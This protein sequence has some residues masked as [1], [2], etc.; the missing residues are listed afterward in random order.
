MIAV[1]RGRGCR[2]TREQTVLLGLVSEELLG[3]QVLR[4][5]ALDALSVEALLTEARSQ[6]VELMAAEAVLRRADAFGLSPEQITALQSFA[7]RHLAH[8]LKIAFSQE[9][10]IR[11]L[12]DH[13]YLILKGMAAAAY[14][15]KPHQRRQG[16]VDFLIDAGELSE[17]SALLEQN[18]YQKWQ[19]E[20]V[21]HVVFKKPGA[22]LEMHF[23]VSGIPRGEAGE[24]IRDALAG[25]VDRRK[26]VSFDDWRFYA[27]DD[28]DQALILLLHMQHHMLAEGLGVRH[29][30]DWAAFTDR[31][32]DAPFWQSLMP[33]LKSVGLL[34]YAQVLT[35]TCALFFGSACPAWAD[36]EEDLCRAV[37]EDVLAGGNFGRKDAV[38]SAGGYLI[39][40]HGKEGTEK[41]MTK[42]AWFTLVHSTEL[43]YPQVK[44]HPVLWGVFLPV[45]ATRLGWRILR[46]KIAIRPA[47]VKAGKERLGV[48][49]RLHLFEIEGDKE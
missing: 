1:G 31:T 48:Y 32:A 36:A 39:S 2:M 21:C 16:D 44:K 43:H 22:H 30:C 8:G 14:Y 38:R 33:L 45:R 23:E 6:A 27:P 34:T 4:E 42:N 24:R 26:E 3:K 11:L 17:L 46:G 40:Q 37:M 7:D 5:E 13:P 12:G 9:E 10:L 19:E 28:R 35:K 47:S 25:A 20:H 15:A 29:L 18:G 49:E 41:S